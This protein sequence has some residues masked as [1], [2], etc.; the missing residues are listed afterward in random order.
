MLNVFL[1]FTSLVG[2]SRLGIENH[3]QGMT[4]HGQNN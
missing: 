4:N 1:G 2:T 3:T